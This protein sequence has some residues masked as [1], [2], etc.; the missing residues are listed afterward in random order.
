M[1]DWNGVLLRL[2]LR[3][4]ERFSDFAISSG[5]R[6]LNTLDSRSSASLVLVTFAD[7]RLVRL[8]LLACR[9]FVLPSGRFFV[10]VVIVG[11]PSA[12]S[13]FFVELVGKRTFRR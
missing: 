10:A 13:S 1:A 12:R 5:F 9:L 7:Q 4:A 2:R 3:S 6:L 11:L 8:R